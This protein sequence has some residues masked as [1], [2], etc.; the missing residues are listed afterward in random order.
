MPKFHLSN[1]KSDKKINYWQE[2]KKLINFFDP[3]KTKIFF[4]FIISFISCSAVIGA[5]YL[6][7]YIFDNYFHPAKLLNFDEKGFIL[8]LI[9]LVICYA[10]GQLFILITNWFS[11][12][13]AFRTASQMRQKAYDSLM[14]MP[15][16]YFEKKNSGRL[17]S[18]LSN[19]IDNVAYGLLSF[20]SQTMLTL[21]YTV[22]CLIFVFIYSPYLGLITL[23][24]LPILY[25]FLIIFVKKAMPMFR[26]QQDSLS[27]VNGFVE[28]IIKGQHIINSFNRIE[29]VDLRFKQYNDD[30]VKPAMKAG[31]YSGITFPYS[32]FASMAIQMIAIAIGSIFVLKGING[33]NGYLTIGSLSVIRIYLVMFTSQFIQTMNIFTTIQMGIAS[34]SR[35]Q[36]LLELKP[37]IDNSKLNTIGNIKGDVKF[38]NVDFSYTDDPKNLQL[39]HATFWAKKGQSIAIVGPTGAGKTT[40]VNLLS[41]FYQPL[42]GTI[43]IDDIDISTISE[44]SWRDKISVVLQDTYLFKG[45]ILENLRYG[46]LE[47][48]REQ[49]IN[50]S[51]MAHADEFIMKLEKGYDTVIDQ[52]GTILS[53]GE[54]QLIAIARAILSNKDILILDEAT[55]NVDVH[56]EQNIQKAMLNLMQGKT[57]FVIAHRLSTIVNATCILVIN[58]GE[59]IEKG[60]HKE[61]LAQK[62]MY[63]KMYHSNF[64]DND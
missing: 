51:K 28:E 20:I 8:M 7:G 11:V 33:G 64:E 39:K 15:L 44:S 31:I 19:D 55:S 46:N 53:Q 34:S 1:H 12:K 4:I 40:I 60:S 47:A 10:L 29:D 54:R 26:K 61:L 58:N 43:K 59:I 24:L 50:A 6:T 38:E 22:L 63:E 3:K 13:M 14:K 52:N 2:L 30:L 45:T 9:Y 23:G 42:S 18:T 35:V 57:S 41:K 49:I 25:S 36:E 56:T 62:G 48:S 17:M 21:C 5:N 16:S 37:I 32:N 27:A